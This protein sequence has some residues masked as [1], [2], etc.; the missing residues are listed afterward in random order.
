MLRRWS[1]AALL[2][3][4]VPLLAWLG[5]RMD[6]GP[7]EH[8]AGPPAVPAPQAWPA[9]PPSLTSAAAEARPSAPSVDEIERRLFQ[10][11]SLRGAGWD[12]AWGVDAQGRLQPSL[13]LRRRFDQLLSTLGEVGVDEL[14]RLLQARARAELA[15]EAAEAVM[16][17]WQRYLQLQRRSYRWGLDGQDFTRW[18][19]ALAERQAARRELLGRAWADAFYAEEE[20]ALR[21]HLSGREPA[22]DEARAAAAGLA[23][24]P[25]LARAPQPGADPQQL[26][27]QRRQALGLE[28]AQR[29]Q[30]EDAAQA[31][32]A[33]RLAQ[34]RE[35]QARLAGSSE[36]S[37]AQRQLA[38]EQWL[39]SRFSAAERLR[40][41]AL[42][43]A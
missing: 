39:A 18:E 9:S 30:A 10:R 1:A 20:A 25:A 33:A 34:A 12:G 3:A 43:G 19:A 4:A 11:G 28:A 14:G 40:V 6:R 13:A 23:V 42:L 38:L 22:A 17:V 41:R 29:L 8:P 15:P 26:F 2:A 24:L 7:H 27:E 35:E 5:L 37:A 32:W 36:L 21:A 31:D 16:Q